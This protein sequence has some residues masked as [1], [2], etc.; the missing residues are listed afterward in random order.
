MHRVKGTVLTWK[1]CMSRADLIEILL[2]PVGMYLD[3][4]HNEEKLEQRFTK[5]IQEI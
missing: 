4:S 5:N 1:R 2:L 3:R